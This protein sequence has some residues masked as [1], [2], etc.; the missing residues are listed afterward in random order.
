MPFSPSTLYSDVLFIIYYQLLSLPEKILIEILYI[1]K[2]KNMA[3]QT[4]SVCLNVNIFIINTLLM[5]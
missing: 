4:G 2:P 1:I 3:F 5:L